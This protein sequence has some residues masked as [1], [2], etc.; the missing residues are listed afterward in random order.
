MQSVLNAYAYSRLLNR[1]TKNSA[2][3]ITLRCRK[4]AEAK[5]DLDTDS[6][7]DAD[8]IP[9]GGKNHFLWLTHRRIAA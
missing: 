2:V 7:P 3:G 9:A 8:V 6:D 5:S 4:E 1:F